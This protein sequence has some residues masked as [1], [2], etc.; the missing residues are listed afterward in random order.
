MGPISPINL[1]NENLLSLSL[2]DAYFHLSVSAFSQK[3]A[4]LTGLTR[5]ELVDSRAIPL[6]DI[7]LLRQ[8]QLQE[9]VL[10]NSTAI[11]LKLLV[12][13]ALSWLKKLHMEDS[14][15]TSNA[16]AGRECMTAEQLQNLAATR[17]AIFQL[18]E[19]HQL[20]GMC[21]LFVAGM[22]QGKIKWIVT[23]CAEGTMVSDKASHRCPVHLM[24]IWTKPSS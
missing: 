12:P 1:A 15:C 3:L 14:G 18:P 5:L 8:L 7:E 22:R 21:N 20:S 10:I 6:R 11:A 2:H 4:S 16:R 17:H 13:G 24:K 9:L 19:L 23:P